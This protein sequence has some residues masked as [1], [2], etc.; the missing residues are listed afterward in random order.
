MQEHSTKCR[1]STQKPEYLTWS[2][3]ELPQLVCKQDSCLLV[4]PLG[5]QAKKAVLKL[6]WYIHHRLEGLPSLTD[7]PAL[8]VHASAF[9]WV[10]EDSTSW[11]AALT[12]P[13]EFPLRL[14]KMLKTCSGQGKARL[15]TTGLSPRP[16]PGLPPRTE[17]GQPDCRQP[18]PAV[19][20]PPLVAIKHSKV[21]EPAAKAA[22]SKRKAG[23][24][25]GDAWSQVRGPQPRQR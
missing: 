6:S 25:R 5:S 24:E 21:H 9:P 7:N 10:D 2:C 22:F 17:L 19:S 20:D 4:T 18:K 16:T 1:I 23:S 12:F 3:S 13:K 15:H 11:L 8:P 14:R